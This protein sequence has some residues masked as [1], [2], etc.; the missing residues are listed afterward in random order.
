MNFKRMMYSLRFFAFFNAEK[1]GDWARKKG[2]FRATGKSVRLP[3]M[4]IPLYP[5]CIAFHNNIGIGSGVRLVT[6]D[7]LHGLFNRM[8]IENAGKYQEQIGCIEIMDNVFIGA[9]SIV[10]GNVRI[11]P[12]VIVGA[13]ALINRDLEPNS[14]YAGVPARKVGTFEDEAAVRRQ[15]AVCADSE[16]RWKRFFK[17]RETADVKI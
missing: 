12:N 4:L 17:S 3:A 7:A 10:L 16:E 6:H 1:R 9:N 5:E 8:E 11:G 2:I 14:V 15:I 13:G